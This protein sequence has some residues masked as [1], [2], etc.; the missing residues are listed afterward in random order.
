[1]K[2]FT[3]TIDI[4]APAHDVY[5]ALRAVDG[6]PSWLKH[7]LV[8]HGTR[9]PPKQET[10]PA[11]TDS[12]M[13]GRMRGELIDDIPDHELRFHQ[14]KQSGRVD[15]LIVY[16]IDDSGGATRV[17][18]VGRLTTH[19]VYRAVEPIF[20]RMAAAESRRTM[21]ALKTHVEHER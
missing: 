5:S 18:R 11:Y 17:T 4:N 9:V 6:Y 19:G 21:E 3:N 16:D 20:V 15:A 8:Y 7:S 13:I 2:S 10:P 12:T 14:A 1:M